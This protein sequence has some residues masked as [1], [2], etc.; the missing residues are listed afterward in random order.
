MIPGYA[1]YQVAIG[2]HVNNFNIAWSGISNISGG[3]YYQA[4]Q[5]FGYSS[6]NHSLE[7][8]ISM[9]TLGYGKGFRFNVFGLR[10]GYGVFGKGGLNIGKFR[11]E[12]L[13][14][15]PSAG[16]GFGTIFSM[17][18]MKQGGSIFRWDYG[19][20]HHGGTGFH[21]TIRFYLNGSKYGSTAQRSWYPPYFKL[22]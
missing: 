22:K 20:L 19:P 14:E 18:Q 15:N 6:G 4:G 7:L 12:A 3:N 9:L 13:Y 10:G 21:S 5:I 16:R 8:G 17:K 1:A 2:T 11:I